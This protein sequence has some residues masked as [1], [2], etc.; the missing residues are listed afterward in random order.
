MGRYADGPGRHSGHGRLRRDVARDDGSRTDAGARTDLYMVHDAG[1]GSDVDPVAYDGGRGGDVRPDGS[2]LAHVDI[3]ADDGTRRDDRAA[4]VLEVESVAD[5]RARRD[6]QP[7]A[8]VAVGH[9]LGERVEPA[10]VLREPEPERE[11][12]GGAR[13]TAQPDA[14]EAVAPA[15]V[16]E[17][18]GADEF[19]AVAV[20]A[21]YG[22]GHFSLP[23]PVF[24]EVHGVRFCYALS[25]MD[26]SAYLS[27]SG[28]V[29]SLADE[30]RLL[31]S[32]SARGSGSADQRVQAR[33]CPTMSMAA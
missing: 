27:R 31:R 4:A 8:F 10:L 16:A 13:Q 22:H 23:D 14:E 26:C 5:A 18:V 20:A 21:G 17:V 32:R 30:S 15:A 29:C 19:G 3:V 6:Q 28:R 7:V 24:L 2:Q 12:D 1:A 25:S 33:R 9:H 11:A